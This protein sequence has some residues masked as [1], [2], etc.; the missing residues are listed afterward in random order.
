MLA[1][2]E[3]NKNCTGGAP[4]GNLWRDEAAFRQEG[5]FG[6]ENSDDPFKDEH[7][8]NPQRGDTTW[9]SNVLNIWRSH[10]S[11]AN[12]LLPLH[13]CQKRKKV[14]Q[15]CTV[16]E[17]SVSSQYTRAL[18]EC[19]FLPFFWNLT[20]AAARRHSSWSLMWLQHSWQRENQHQL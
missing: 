3:L 5:S 1:V 13:K 6:G 11:G 8:L 4:R 7:R 19:C 18:W 15:N 17:F 20:S 14:S 9:P 10:G 16:K 2:M 12:H